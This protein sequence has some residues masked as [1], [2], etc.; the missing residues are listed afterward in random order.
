MVYMRANLFEVI[1]SCECA[2]RLTLDEHQMRRAAQPANWIALDKC[3]LG[4][5]RFYAAATAAAFTD[6]AAAV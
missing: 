1:F 6:I 4:A 3:R 5:R 2:C